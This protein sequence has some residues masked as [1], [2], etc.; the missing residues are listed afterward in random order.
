MTSTIEPDGHLS[1]CN[2][3]MTTI[4]D[5]LDHMTATQRLGSTRFLRC[6]LIEGFECGGVLS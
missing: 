5:R 2:W 4:R 3:G 1:G 6:H